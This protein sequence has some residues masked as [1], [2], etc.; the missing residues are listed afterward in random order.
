MA[1]VSVG[2]VVS[3]SGLS[4]SKTWR[5]SLMACSS[6]MGASFGCFRIASSNCL[7][8]SM[9]RSVGVSSGIAMA[10]C[11]NLTVSDNCSAPVD[12]RIPLKVL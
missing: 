5:S 8:A 2:L 1:V 11:L 4:P 12:G 10:W 9:M 3:F 6:S 7:V